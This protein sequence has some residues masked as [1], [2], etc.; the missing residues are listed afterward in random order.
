VSTFCVGFVYIVC[1]IML[2]GSVS[3]LSVVK[4]LSVFAL[5][6]ALCVVLFMFA[7]YL[8]LPCVVRFCFV[9]L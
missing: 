8:V 2:F 3:F 7:L 6:V 5:C 1:F 4:S 9:S